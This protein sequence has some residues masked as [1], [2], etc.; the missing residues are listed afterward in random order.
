MLVKNLTFAIT[1][2]CLPFVAKALCDI[3]GRD[4][5]EICR[6]RSARYPT[7]LLCESR[8]IRSGTARLKTL[9]TRTRPHVLL[10]MAAEQ[11]QNGCLFHS[12]CGWNC[13]WSAHKVVTLCIWQDYSFWLQ[14]DVRIRCA[15]NGCFFFTIAF[16]LKL[17]VEK[18]QN[19]YY[20]VNTSHN[21]IWGWSAMVISYSILW[22]AQNG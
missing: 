14:C 9:Y 1:A 2:V 12:C 16:T 20:M 22:H 4:R 18:T 13:G 19:G 21:V 5:V 11:T 7:R 15:V 17:S 3:R 8:L 10:W 6:Y